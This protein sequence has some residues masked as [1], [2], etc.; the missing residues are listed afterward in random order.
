M[1]NTI[2]YLNLHDC[3]NG[4]STINFEILEDANFKIL[5]GHWVHSDWFPMNAQ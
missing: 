3:T 2:F 1:K 4:S 5:S